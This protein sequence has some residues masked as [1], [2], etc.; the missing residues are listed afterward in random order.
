[1]IDLR[2]ASGHPTLRA[3]TRWVTA[4]VRSAPSRPLPRLAEV[5]PGPT[6]GGRWVGLRTVPTECIRGTASMAAAS[7]GVDFR[8]L[9]G[10][11]PADWRY[12]WS[13]LVSAERD[14]VILPPVELIRAGGDYWVLDGHNR[15]A[16]AKENGQLWVDADI[17]EVDLASEHVGATSAKEN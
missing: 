16:L 3:L 5:H 8:P 11:A 13:R 6:T 15:V 2:Q 12:R 4:S 1:M 9:P 14:Q 10:R 17:T 7:R